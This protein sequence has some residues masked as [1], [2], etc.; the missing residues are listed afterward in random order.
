MPDAK[1]FLSS[2]KGILLIIEIIFCMVILICFRN[3]Q[4]AYISLSSIEMIL[5]IIFVVLYVCDVDKKAQFIIWIDFFRS[6]IGAILYLI[7]S[8]MILVEDHDKY[9]I[10]GAILGILATIIFGYDASI[11]NPWK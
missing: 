1:T 6:L 4:P 3:S 9:R 7:S 8:V 10:T 2:P 11:T 5:A